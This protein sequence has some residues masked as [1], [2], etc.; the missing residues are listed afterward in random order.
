MTNQPRLGS[1]N[2]NCAFE[3]KLGG[4]GESDAAKLLIDLFKS[5]AQFI[6]TVRNHG[7]RT[8]H[9]FSGGKEERARAHPPA[10]RERLI[11]HPPFVGADSDLISS[12]LLN[13][14]HICPLWR[15]R[16]MMAKGRTF[17]RH[18]DIAD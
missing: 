11:F 16:F 4:T 10:A 12:A 6:P 3:H 15:K 14:V 2:L 1:S 9:V 13:E 18:I 8:L 17:S 5:D 7:N